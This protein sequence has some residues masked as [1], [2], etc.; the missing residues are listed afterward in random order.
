MAT[1][2][3]E[4]QLK[5]LPS[6]G[7]IQELSEKIADEINILDSSAVKTVKVN[8]V[9]LTA[10][11]NEVDILIGVVKKQTAN[12]GFSAS[13]QITANGTAL[14]QEIDI[15]KDFLV[16]SASMGVA[17]ADDNPI[18]GI[19]Q[20]QPYLDF[21]VNTKE[22]ADAVTDQ[23][24]YINVADLVDTYTPGNGMSLSNNEFSVAIDPT[25]VG[26]LTV[27]ANGVKLALVTADTYTGDTK[28]ADGVAGAMS[29][30]DKYKLDNI[31]A[32]AN[33][34]TVATEKAGTIEVDGI[35]KTIVEF[36]TNAEFTTM[37]NEIWPTA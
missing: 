4:D 26:G 24:I 12:A 25:S 37:M 32:G 1:V 22:T 27:G 14:A 19:L 17:A 3:T 11:N 18:A 16:K 35:T 30:A 31:S 5:K 36:A 28:T 20:G 10:T 6:L 2:L 34:T 7:Q 21:V 15:P 13:Y 23:H 33:R 8:G 9:A 29:S